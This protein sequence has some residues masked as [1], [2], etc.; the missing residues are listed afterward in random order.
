MVRLC[1]AQEKRAFAVSL[2]N[3]N[4]IAAKANPNGQN[5]TMHHVVVLTLAF[6]PE[7]AV[8]KPGLH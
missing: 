1:F 5:P 3:V 8:E 4:S 6:T 2:L 7:T